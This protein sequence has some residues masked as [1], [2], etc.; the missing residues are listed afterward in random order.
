MIGTEATNSL[1]YLARRMPR[2][3]TG[4]AIIEYIQLRMACRVSPLLGMVARIEVISMGSSSRTDIEHSL[5]Y[6]I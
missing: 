2:A 6:A 3:Q 5:D 4:R 1:D